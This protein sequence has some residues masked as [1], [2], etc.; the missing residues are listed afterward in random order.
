MGRHFAAGKIV[1]DEEAAPLVDRE[2]LR[3]PAPPFSIFDIDVPSSL[4]V[5]RTA[6]IRILPAM[7][8]GKW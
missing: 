5:R 6:T 7:T 4:A 3:S 2:L 8:E 1:I